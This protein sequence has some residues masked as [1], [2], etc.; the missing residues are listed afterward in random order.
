MNL[1]RLLHRTPSPERNICYINHLNRAC[2]TITP[3]LTAQ[4]SMAPTTDDELE[5]TTKPEATEAHELRESQ[6]NDAS[7][8]TRDQQAAPD[9]NQ[10][11][12]PV[13]RLF[14]LP[15]EIRTIIFGFACT[16]EPDIKLPGPNMTGLSSLACVLKDRHWRS[17]VVEAIWQNCSVEWQGTLTS[18]TWQ[19]FKKTAIPGIRRLTITFRLG[20]WFVLYSDIRETLA[21][22][23]QRSRRG[24][25]ARY[26]WYLEQLRLRGVTDRDSTALDHGDGH[27]YFGRVRPDPR[28]VHWSQD[29][30]LQRLRR[31]GITVEAE[32]MQVNT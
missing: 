18:R 31:Y 11:H 23:W 15:P 29:F 25:K 3:S 20:S 22:M 19:R 2:H 10:V 14:T 30:S 17:E 5:E 13:F 4:G 32:V 27:W 9:A 26:P 28:R 24:N 1:F 8:V 12:Q 21:W 16:E 7:D 6:G